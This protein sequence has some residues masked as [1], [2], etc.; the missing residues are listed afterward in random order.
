MK[1][2]SYSVVVTLLLYSVDLP[3]TVSV[4]P[5]AIKLPGSTMV[6]GTGAPSH[7]I[8]WSISGTLW[9]IQTYSSLVPCEKSFASNTTPAN[10]LFKRRSISPGS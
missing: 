10:S 5:Y 2:A 8:A 1:T 4:S 7:G 3:I 6:R 9:C